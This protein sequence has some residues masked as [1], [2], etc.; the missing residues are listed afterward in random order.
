MEVFLVLFVVGD[1]LKI[2]DNLSVYRIELLPLRW[3]KVLKPCGIVP[4]HEPA[5]LK[6]SN[7]LFGSQAAKKSKL[8]E[9]Y[10]ILF[11]IEATFEKHLQKDR[12][13]LGY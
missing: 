2:F 7:F 9:D 6:L 5:Y 10:V 3:M 11:F 12:G 13:I 1:D 8:A 4:I